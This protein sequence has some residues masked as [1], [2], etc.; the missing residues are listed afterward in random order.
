MKH[1]IKN[2]YLK[3]FIASLAVAVASIGLV[4]YFISKLIQAF[5]YILMLERE[6]AKDIMNDFWSIETIS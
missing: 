4:L 6:S 5:A 1:P 2:K 3:F